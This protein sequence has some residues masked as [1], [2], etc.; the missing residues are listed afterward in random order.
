MGKKSLLESTSGKKTTAKKSAAKKSAAKK[1]AAKTAARTKKPAGVK[2]TAVKAASAKTTPKS[3]AVKSKKAPAAKKTP[4]RKTE[5]KKAAKKKPTIKELLFKKFDHGEARPV[6]QPPKVTAPAGAHDAPSFFAG[7]SDADTKRGKALLMAKFDYA[8]I[9]AAGKKAAADKAPPGKAAGEKAAAAKVPPPQKPAAP[10]AP[11]PPS[12]AVAVQQDAPEPGSKFLRNASIAVAA[13]IFM[14]LV[15][16][17]TNSRDYYIIE[18]DGTVEIRRGS[19]APMGDDPLITLT[20]VPAPEVPKDVY[21]WQEAYT[22]IYTYYINRADTLVEAPGV[23]D[24]GA[25]KENLEL[26]V[27]YAPD[28][29]MMEGA[30]GRLVSLNLQL[31][32]QKASA[33]INRRT[34]ESVQ[35]GLDIL[36]SAKTMGLSEAET[37]MVDSQIASAEALLTKLEAEKAEADRLAEEQTALETEKETL[38]GAAETAAP[39]VAEESGQ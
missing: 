33:A 22:L 5:V 38:G 34:I 11:T 1:A 16:S 12:P 3:A 32:I 28:R 31:A 30:K 37:A 8:E 10:S 7:M 17:Y 13:V 4:I 35:K 26:A 23:P 19:F 9:R 20:G 36:K 29:E 14:L 6:W 24:A 25:L 21:T 15:Y 27:K 18:K 39:P 2:K